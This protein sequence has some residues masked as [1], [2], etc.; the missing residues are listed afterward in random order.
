MP[1]GRSRSHVQSGAWPATYGRAEL[2]PCPCVLVFA[3]VSLRVSCARG[4]HPPSHQLRFLF[5]KAPPWR[6][7]LRPEPPAAEI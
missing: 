7:L 2:S 6:G 4:T 1:M 5:K 3:S